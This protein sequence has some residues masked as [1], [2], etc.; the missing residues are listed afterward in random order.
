[1]A[2]RLTSGLPLCLW[3]FTVTYYLWY[4]LDVAYHYDTIAYAQNIRSFLE[5]GPLDRQLPS[6][7]FNSVYYLPFVAF[8]GDA[9]IKYANVLVLALFLPV[10][11]HVVRT[12][13]CWTVATSAALLVAFAPA[14]VITVTH[15]KE[16]LNAVLFLVAALALLQSGR[17]VA[18]G[19]AGACYGLAIL[20]KE[21]AIVLF[22]FVAFYAPVAGLTGQSVRQI[23]RLAFWRR[24]APRTIV[25]VAFLLITMVALSPDHFGIVRSMIEGSGYLRVLMPFSPMQSV[26]FEAWQKGSLYLSPA[27]LLGLVS[28]IAAIRGRQWLKLWWMGAAVALFFLFSNTTVVRDRQFIPVILLVAPSIAEGVL[29]VVVGVQQWFA[30][31][32]R[33]REPRHATEMFLVIAVALGL[34][35]AHAWRLQ[36]TLMYRNRY[37]A[38]REYFGELCRR[39]PDGAHV[40]GM[41]MILFAAHFAGDKRVNVYRHKVQPSPRDARQ[42]VARMRDQLDTG[43]VF[44]LPDFFAYDAR[45][46]LQRGITAVFESEGFYRH[47]LEAYRQMSYLD[48]VRTVLER[49]ERRFPQ[50]ELI[51]RRQQPYVL[52]DGLKAS[53]VQFIFRAQGRLFRHT[54]VEFRGYHLPLT[55]RTVHRLLPKD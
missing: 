30:P 28:F 35:V 54:L 44:L 43:E 8:A 7:F 31:G 10:Y 20:S 26:G 12:F 50:A 5:G 29:L 36:P 55:Y 40:Y 45:G 22:P 46:H 47:P 24:W 21:F 41:E 14:T 39:L 1:M 42:L 19:V 15:L 32:G 23:A 33:D 37:H 18:T 53:K 3:L 51:G 4:T 38:Q 11:A 34:A 6:R 48:P 27:C 17:F 52:S 16:D 13:A 25:F 9:G 49:I 2:K